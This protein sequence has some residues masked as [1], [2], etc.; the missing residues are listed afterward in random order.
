MAGL[1]CGLT[2]SAATGSAGRGIRAAMT[3]HVTITTVMA[4]QTNAMAI[5]R[6]R[7]VGA[8]GQAWL[9]TPPGQADD[10]AP[11]GRGDVACQ[12]RHLRVTWPAH[13]HYFPAKA[14]T[15]GTWSGARQDSHSD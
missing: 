3:R 7:A 14:R 12:D 13:R 10:P 1:I 4:A 9:G 15:F 5:S 11:A 2:A 8:P 6:T